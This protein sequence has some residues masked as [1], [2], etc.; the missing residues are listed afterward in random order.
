MNEL[1]NLVDKKL[2][3]EYIQFHHQVVEPVK[4]M[5]RSKNHDLVKGLRS[6]DSSFFAEFDDLDLNVQKKRSKSKSA[7]KDKDDDK[8][9]HLK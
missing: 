5:S 1:I 7:V 8:I 6:K 9:T 3:P 4:S 2:Y